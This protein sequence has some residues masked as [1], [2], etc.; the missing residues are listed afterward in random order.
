M[1]IGFAL[2]FVVGALLV[3]AAIGWLTAA[4]GSD[5]QPSTSG[6]VLVPEGTELYWDEEK[7]A[8][9]VRVGGGFMAVSDILESRQ[10]L[11]EL[12]EAAEQGGKSA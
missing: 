6:R 1:A 5:L 7:D 12:R 2:G 4:F 10:S 9:S 3:L 8:I 11:G